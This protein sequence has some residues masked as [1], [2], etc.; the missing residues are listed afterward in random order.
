MTLNAYTVTIQLE[1]GKTAYE[2]SFLNGVD[3]NNRNNKAITGAIQF[4]EN[5]QKEKKIG[6]LVVSQP[7]TK[8]GKGFALGSLHNTYS[9]IQNDMGNWVT[10]GEALSFLRSM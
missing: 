7:C 8:N 6:I 10:V 2:K 9:H 5:Q 4:L 3:G 1:A